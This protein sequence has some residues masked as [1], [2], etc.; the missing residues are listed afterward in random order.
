MDTSKMSVRTL[1]SGVYFAGKEHRFSL[2]VDVGAYFIGAGGSRGLKA[3]F[4]A[5]KKK[6]GIEKPLKYQ[7]VTHHH[8]DHIE[9]L[10][11]ITELGTNFITVGEH[12]ASIQDSLPKKLSK[13][14]FIIVKDNAKYANGLVEVYNMSSTHSD[15]NLLTYIPKVKLM[16]TADH[17]STDLKTDLPNADKG[18]VILM[19]EI[20]R[21]NLDIEKF[22]GAHGARILTMSDLKK[23]VG[24][25]SEAKC[26]KGITVCN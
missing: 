25:Y 18:T 22:L 15:Q 5:V 3:R 24:H 16:F 17:F 7:V 12:I 10:S 23:V 9:G 6:M 4:E 14:R 26:P 11:S 8:S 2:F 13:D 1:A 20:N 21:L 19:D